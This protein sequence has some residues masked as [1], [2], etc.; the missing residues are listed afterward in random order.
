MSESRIHVW[1]EESGMPVVLTVDEAA[2]ALAL[3]DELSLQ[4]RKFNGRHG[5][6]GS[7][8]VIDPEVCR[9]LLSARTPEGRDGLDGTWLDE[10]R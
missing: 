3:D 6:G 9:R 1:D 4:W 10:R 5:R 2:V 8:I 7:L